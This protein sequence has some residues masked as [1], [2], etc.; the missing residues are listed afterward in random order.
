MPP[1]LVLGVLMV[2]S[3]F[4]PG[5]TLLPQ[6]LVTLPK[7]SFNHLQNSIIFYCYIII[8]IENA[9]LLKKYLTINALTLMVKNTYTINTQCYNEYR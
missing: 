3:I 7:K 6:L 9:L 4:V 8:A 2:N 1:K 5:V